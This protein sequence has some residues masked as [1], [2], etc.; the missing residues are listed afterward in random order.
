MVVKPIVATIDIS[1]WWPPFFEALFVH[2]ISNKKQYKIPITKLQIIPE[3]L[4]TQ[5]PNVWNVKFE[6]WNLFAIWC[7]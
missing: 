7:L 5:T 2:Y 4:M 3:S 6:T 1:I